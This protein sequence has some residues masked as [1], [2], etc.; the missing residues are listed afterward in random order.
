MKN[1]YQKFGKINQT[2]FIVL[3]FF[4]IAIGFFI[5][6]LTK[7]IYFTTKNIKIG[8]LNINDLTY[9]IMIV[10]SSIIAIYSALCLIIT[11]IYIYKIVNFNYQEKDKNKIVKLQKFE[12]FINI[13]TLN[14][15]MSENINQI[16]NQ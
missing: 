8:R 5:F 3:L 10:L 15:H 16:N 13:F 9:I 14:K 6:F 7:K 1:K 4:V 2:Y 11:N 12:K